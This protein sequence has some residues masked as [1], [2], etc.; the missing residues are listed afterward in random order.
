M[1][2]VVRFGKMRRL[3]S[4]LRQK[5][6]PR[7]RHLRRP[8][9]AQTLDLSAP[10][11]VANPFPHYEDLR[12]SGP[13]HF[14]PLNGYWLIIGYDEVHSALMRPQVFS[15]RV[16][17]WMA[18]DSVLLG[19]DPPQHTAARHAVSRLFSAENLEA[20]AAFAEQSAER[21]LRPLVAGEELDVLR[22]FAG[23]LSE[24][25]VAHLIGFDERTLAA[26]RAAQNS[27]N[28]LGQWLK[29]LGAVIADPAGQTPAY[30][31]L[32]RDGDGGLSHADV[33]SL[34][35]FLWIAGITTTR[36]AIASSVL[37]LLRNP[38]ARTQ[39]ESDSALLPAFV[40]ETIRMHP[41]EHMI[42]RV[43]AT[44]VELAGAKM[45]AGALVNLCMGAANR[46]PARFDNPASFL[47][48]RAPNRHLSF[49]G[50]IHR[51]VGAS[52]ARV[53]IAAALRVLLRL[54]PRFRSVQPL[55]TL[56]YAGFAND[57]EQLVIE[58]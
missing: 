32:L 21:L 48:H 7:A 38:A 57:T 28:D 40:E 24:D 33:Q 16:Q 5:I 51:C 49:G 15:S 12:R 39:V 23:P 43:T 2:E 53:E 45:P 9:T 11:V 47:L 37:M 27:A 4:R 35:R 3:A 50:G 8:S 52:L 17:V 42:A 31:R 55:D 44:E 26:A 6:A 14:L 22:D 19:A 46:D 25:V 20:Q 54:A 1:E 13:V 10:E 41:P 18:V 29:A 36:R 34:I 58:C 30:N 56:G